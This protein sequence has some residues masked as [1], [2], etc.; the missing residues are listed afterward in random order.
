MYGC[1][2][3]KLASTLGKPKGQGRKLKRQMERNNPALK[4]LIDALEL[5]YRRGYLIGLDGRHL[6]IRS[7]RK[8]LNSLLQGG[9]AVVFKQWMVEVD[10]YLKEIGCAKQVIAYH[11][12]VQIE[13]YESDKGT[14]ESIG[15]RVCQLALEVG[16][17]LGIRVPVEAE[18]KVGKNWAETH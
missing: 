4:S 18:Y 12:E 11:D 15:Q 8:L 14:A 9:A 3:A 7:S 6:D 16:Q 13:C 10:R 1:G 17:K 2:D 5:K